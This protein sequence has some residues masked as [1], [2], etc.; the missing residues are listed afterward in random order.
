M[1]K[2]SGRPWFAAAATEPRQAAAVSLALFFAVPAAAALTVG[3][4]ERLRH[5]SRFDPTCAPYETQLPRSRSS[6]RA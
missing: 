1:I 3:M 6:V 5:P 2:P 4:I